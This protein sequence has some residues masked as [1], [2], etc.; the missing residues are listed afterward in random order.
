MKLIHWG[1]KKFD[2]ELW[3]SI[4]NEQW[5]KPRGGLWSSPVDSTYGWKQWCKD[6]GFRK[7]RADN[8]FIFELMPAS[9]IL[10]INSLEDLQAALKKYRQTGSHHLHSYLDYAKIAI[11]YDAIHL[12][13]E[14]Q[15]KT[16]YTHPNLY[17]WDC[18]TVL[19]LRRK[20]I[21]H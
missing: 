14:G 4:Q 18:E 10:T 13:E 20:A 17:A 11:N 15:I 16:R 3:Q 12:T 8:H 7:Y 5:V 21:I 19:I 6:E 2:D 1:A 9:K